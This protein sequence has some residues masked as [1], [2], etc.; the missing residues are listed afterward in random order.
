MAKESVVAV[1]VVLTGCEVKGKAKSGVLSDKE[2][3]ALVERALRGTAPVG[4]H[5]ERWGVKTLTR[6]LAARARHAAVLRG[7]ANNAAKAKA[8][9]AKAKPKRRK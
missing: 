5:V 6:H 7:R 2:A 9:K 3:K 8:K 1:A 4:T